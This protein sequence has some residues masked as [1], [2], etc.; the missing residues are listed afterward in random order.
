MGTSL[1]SKATNL[2]FEEY[3]CKSHVSTFFLKFL[4]FDVEGDYCN[5]FK[6]IAKFI[7]LPNR[8]GAYPQSRRFLDKKFRKILIWIKF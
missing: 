5:L 4:Y 6:R 8:N 3:G 1:T 2:R 7:R